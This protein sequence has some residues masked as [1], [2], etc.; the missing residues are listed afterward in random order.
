L[1]LQFSTASL[2]D[3]FLPLPRKIFFDFLHKR[4]D[5]VLIE[6]HDEDFLSENIPDFSTFV[7]S[8]IEI[9]THKITIDLVSVDDDGFLV[10]FNCTVFPFEFEFDS[11]VTKSFCF[12]S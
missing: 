12:T 2:Y 6:K 4:G 5:E 7:V 10:P 9:L 1:A 11:D 3:F 8:T